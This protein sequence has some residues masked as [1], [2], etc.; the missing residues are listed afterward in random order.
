[1][2]DILQLL[3]QMTT[4]LTICMRPGRTLQMSRYMV[5]L[6]PRNKVIYCLPRE[7]I[8]SPYKRRSAQS[9]SRDTQD[10]D[11]QRTSQRGWTWIRGAERDWEFPGSR[12]PHVA[13][14]WW[15]CPYCGS[16]PGSG[17]EAGRSPTSV[18]QYNDVIKYYVDRFRLEVE[19][20]LNWTSQA[21]SIR[22]SPTTLSLSGAS[23]S[24]TSTL[25]A[26]TQEPWPQN[27][28]PSVAL[29]S[30]PLAYVYICV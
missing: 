16:R 22:P 8:S 23:E 12:W 26:P 28:L 17:L 7:T 27:A 2:T 6:P 14:A 10:E 18:V 15:R 24:R 9:R 5:V 29:Q 4:A 1:M 30:E 11:E 21:R 3:N 25:I 13:L 20:I 19:G